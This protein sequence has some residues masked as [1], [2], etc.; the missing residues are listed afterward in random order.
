MLRDVERKH[1]LSKEFILI[2]GDVVGNSDLN[3]AIKFHQE[4][5]N[6]NKDYVMTKVFRKEQVNSR[7]R[8]RE[9]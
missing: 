4:L 9:D 3:D 5:R 7:L 2:F 1:N 8:T 6:K